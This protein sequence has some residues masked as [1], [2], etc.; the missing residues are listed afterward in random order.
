MITASS[1][2]GKKSYGVRPPHIWQIRSPTLPRNRVM[3]EISPET[4]KPI[5]IFKYPARALFLPPEI[6]AEWPKKEAVSA[7]RD[8]LVKRSKGECPYCAGPLGRGHMHEKE[9]RGD[10]GEISLE[11]SIMICAK[12]HIG[13]KGEHKN[14]APQWTR[15]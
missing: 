10:G 9:H 11:N 5:R 8:E 14:R 4:K 7:I 3:C 2:L 12:C 1:I 13:P 6:V 15:S